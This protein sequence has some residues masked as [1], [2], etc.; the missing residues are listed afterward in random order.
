MTTLHSLQSL[1]KGANTAVS[2]T[3][4]ATAAGA[5]TSGS[6][7][8]S[9]QAAVAQ[10]AHIPRYDKALRQGRGDR[11]ERSAW[12]TITGKSMSYDL[13]HIPF[14]H[15]RLDG[16]VVGQFHS[17]CCLSPMYALPTHRACGRGAI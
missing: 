6:K 3:Q 16:H 17:F 4:S 14:A 1:R 10:V 7:K 12:T 8:A 9:P 13:S 5:T 15:S 11:L 2:D